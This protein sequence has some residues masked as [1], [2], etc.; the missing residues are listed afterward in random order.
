MDDSY[1]SGIDKVRF[2][3]VRVKIFV[4]FF[5]RE[6]RD[7]INQVRHVHSIQTFTGSSESH[8]LYEKVFT[9]HDPR[10]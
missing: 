4:I 1:V 8:I 5:E 10:S 6:L 9:D 7:I 2:Y 3:F